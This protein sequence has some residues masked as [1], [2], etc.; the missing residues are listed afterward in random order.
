MTFFAVKNIDNLFL[1]GY[2]ILDIAKNVL[3]SDT[4]RR[5]RRRDAE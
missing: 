3:N 1:I 2:Y 4:L 5:L